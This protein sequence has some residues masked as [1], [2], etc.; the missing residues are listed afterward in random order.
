MDVLIVGGGI[1]GLTTAFWL[2]RLGHRPTVLERAPALRAGGY[3]I[4]FCGPGYTIAE[5]MG[6][7]PE[8]LNRH[9]AIP[10]VRRQLEMPAHCVMDE[11]TLRSV[12]PHE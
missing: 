12:L 7:E 5:R 11:C 8:L 6:L 3:V 1:A 4:D 9:V 10:A 2:E